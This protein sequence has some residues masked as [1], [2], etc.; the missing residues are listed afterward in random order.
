MDAPH[1]LLITRSGALWAAGSHRKQACPASTI[2]S[3]QR[4]LEFPVD[5]VVKVAV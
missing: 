2:L 1:A 3:R 5:Y 4:Q